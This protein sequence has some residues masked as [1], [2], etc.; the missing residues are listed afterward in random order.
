MATYFADYVAYVDERKRP[1]GFPHEVHIHETYGE[2]ENT[3]HLKAIV[4]DRFVK[5]VTGAGLVVLKDPSEILDSTTI[6]FD[7][8]RFIPWHCLTHMELK[9]TLLPEPSRPQ[10]LLIQETPGTKEAKQIIQ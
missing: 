2:V 5:L 6:T 4:N 7:K 9:V 1:E 10:D 3:E 8:R